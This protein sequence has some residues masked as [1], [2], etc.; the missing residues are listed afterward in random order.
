MYN[1]CRTDWVLA[2]FG[3]EEKLRDVECIA[4][5]EYDV[6][7]C[8]GDRVYT[9]RGGFRIMSCDLILGGTPQI[10]RYIVSRVAE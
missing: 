2:T 3:P 5:V 10:R 4:S 1:K 6:A 7:M 8:P 9:A